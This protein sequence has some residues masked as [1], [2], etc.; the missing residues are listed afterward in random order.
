MDDER[1]V[2]VIMASELGQ[3]AFCAR[4]WWLDSVQGYP[5]SHKLEMV[6]GHFAHRAHGRV[7]ARH[8]RLQRL[9]YALLL[10]AVLVATV[11][12]YLLRRGL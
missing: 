8:L 7:V 2:P 1:S 10:L 3:Y 5:S 4:S 11:G 12:I 9:A 6:G